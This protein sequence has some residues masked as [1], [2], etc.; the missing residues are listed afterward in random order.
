MAATPCP[1]DFELLAVIEKD[2]S[3]QDAV[4]HVE[5]CPACQARIKDLALEA[6]SL[7]AAIRRSSKIRRPLGA[8]DSRPAVARPAFVGKYFIAG[9]AE[10]DPHFLTLRALH[11]AVQNEVIIKLARQPA[12]H[13]EAL[14]RSLVD[15]ARALV[16]HTDP[17]VVRVIDFDFHEDRPYLVLAPTAGL[18]SLSSIGLLPPAEALRIAA[19][20]CDLLGAA[21]EKGIVHGSLCPQ[22]VFLDGNGNVRVSDFG[23]AQVRSAVSPVPPN[24]MDLPGPLAHASPQ[25]WAPSAGMATPRD[26]VFSIAAVLFAITTG[27]PVWAGASADSCR[28]EVEQGAIDPAPLH[29]KA[30][31]ARWVRACLAA[32]SPGAEMRPA[33]ARALGRQLASGKP[34][35]WK[36]LVLAF[37]LGLA[38]VVV[39]ALVTAG[40]I[41]YL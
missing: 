39:A 12:P 17:R 10:E 33:D 3:A 40:V 13:D 26:D 4:R 25:R 15:M 36:W 2:E 27:R 19:E 32:L 28:K 9:L 34:A 38:A 16:G 31:N 11:T 35:S 21:H 41:W 5:S 29:E 14:R 6:Q 30:G 20:L 22:C 7:S 1:Q 24:P 18:R 23:L 37:M 8:D